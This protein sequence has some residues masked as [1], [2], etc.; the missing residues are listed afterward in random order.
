VADTGHR[1]SLPNQAE[2]DR[3]TIGRKSSLHLLRSFKRI[4]MAMPFHDGVSFA[5]RVNCAK[6][7]RA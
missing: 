1:L 3:P 2:S 6:P 7:C 4:F 5:S